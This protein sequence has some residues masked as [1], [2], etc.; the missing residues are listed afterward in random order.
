MTGTVTATSLN[1]RAAPAANGPI[2]GVLRSGAS[3]TILKQDDDWL[4]ASTGAGV[5][6][7]SAQYVKLESATAAAAAS[8]A[9]PAQ[10]VPERAVP[11]RDDGVITSDDDHAFAP[12]GS[13]FALKHREGFATLGATT[14]SAFLSSA[15]ALVAAIPP[16]SRVLKNTK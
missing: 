12:D 9:A 13:K 3:V 6:F 16:S 14:I 8:P 11:P 5:G 1:L 4:Q 7:L 15:A 10:G 2:I